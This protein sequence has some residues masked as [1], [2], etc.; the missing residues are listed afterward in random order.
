MDNLKK[1]FINN[2]AFV[3]TES[4][5]KTYVSP[6]KQFKTWCQRKSLRYLLA[7]P[8]IVSL[9]LTKFT[10]S[11]NSCAP[12]LL[13]SSTIF[14]FHSISGFP[15]PTFHSLIKMARD[16]A[17]RTL[18]SGQNKKKPILPSTMRLI[19]LCLASSTCSLFD[20]MKVCLVTLYFAGFLR[21]NE[22][23]NLEWQNILFTTSH[24]SLLLKKSKTDQYSKGSRILIAW[25]GGP[26]CSIYLVE[27]LIHLGNYLAIDCIQS[28]HLL[29]CIIRHVDSSMTIQK[30]GISY[31][32]LQEWF[33]YCLHSIGEN[34][35]FNGTHSRRLGGASTTANVCVPN[36]LF[37]AH[38]C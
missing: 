33:K 38:G 14:F 30:N 1:S 2:R 19:T 31:T 3:C 15:S 16:I 29:R 10:M 5:L 24:M 8:L 6:W 23:I 36:R 11:T 13:A 28:G 18:S 4:I 26:C 22:V 21:S 35:F 17:N 12:I 20:L 32:I 7:E 27:H 34:N 37:K 9:Y 25:L